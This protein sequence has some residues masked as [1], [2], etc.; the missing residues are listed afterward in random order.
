[1]SRPGLSFRRFL[2]WVVGAAVVVVTLAV[3]L[4]VRVLRDPASGPREARA[5]SGTTF[6]LDGAVRLEYPVASSSFL[7]GSGAGEVAATG[8]TPSFAVN[9]TGL[10]GVAEPGAGRIVW[11]VPAF[12][13]WPPIAPGTV[14]IAVTDNGSVAALVPGSANRVDWWHGSAATRSAPVLPGAASGIRTDESGALYAQVDGRWAMVVDAAGHAVPLTTQA[15][16]ATNWEPLGPPGASLKTTSEPGGLRITRRTPTGQTISWDLRSEAPL[17]AT[18]A[19]YLVGET[20]TVGVTSNGAPEAVVLRPDHLVGVIRPTPP[21]TSGEGRWQGDGGRL[22]WL[23]TT[24]SGVRIDSYDLTPAGNPR[25][26]TPQNLAGDWKP[27]GLTGTWPASLPRAPH[28]TLAPAGT[29]NGFDGCN[30]VA[31]NWDLNSAA[32]FTISTDATTL[33][34]CTHT[35]LA[36]P[37]TSTTQVEDGD[38]I[39]QDGTRLIRLTKTTTSPPI[40]TPAASRPTAD[41]IVGTWTLEGF[42][43][44]SDPDEAIPTITF[45]PNGDIEGFDGC[46]QFGGHWTITGTGTLRSTDTTDSA[47]ACTNPSQ[48]APLLTM[49]SHGGHITT[50]QHGLVVTDTAGTTYRLTPAA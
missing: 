4:G 17:T 50:T 35:P 30:D 34:G 26:A 39:L 22:S 31:G 6:D 13:A 9:A 49:L 27:T 48:R 36:L 15:A 1:M 7:W 18:S 28:L 47:V 19:A 42:D 37:A 21:A 44:A 14:A 38:L 43:A 45:S 40:A 41:A 2:P 33:V 32:T 25:P 16:D 5:G 3:G 11:S 46:S 29:W 23:T 8:R 24:S 12:S 20:L 10:A